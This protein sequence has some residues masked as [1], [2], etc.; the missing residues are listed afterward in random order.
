[1][2]HDKKNTTIVEFYTS[3]FDNKTKMAVFLTE[4]TTNR[5]TGNIP[6]LSFMSIEDPP[7]KLASTGHDKCSCGDCPL[8]NNKGCYVVLFQGPNNIFKSFEKGK[9]KK[10]GWNH[11]RKVTKN[12]LVRVGSYGDIMSCPP[13]LRNKIFK[14][15]NKFVG[16]SHSKDKLQEGLL[17]SIEHKDD[18]STEYRTARIVKSEDD[19]DLSREV[20]CPAENKNREI[21][22]NDCGLCGNSVNIKTKSVCFIAHGVKKGKISYEKIYI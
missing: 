17:R 13:E 18:L 1:M 8:R 12:K 7:T 16:Y 22:C 9:I 15:I 20:L 4:M 11:F 5:K 21:T 3:I 14:N 2:K 6:S 19:I 10:E